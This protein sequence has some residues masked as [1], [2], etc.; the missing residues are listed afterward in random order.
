MTNSNNER[1]YG[2]YEGDSSLPA[3]S[4][5]IVLP[6]NPTFGDTNVLGLDLILG[7]NAPIPTL[8]LDQTSGSATLNPLVC[9]QLRQFIMET[10]NSTLLSSQAREQDPLPNKKGEE[11]Q[12]LKAWMNRFLL[13]SSMIDPTLLIL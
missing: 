8:A 9:E 7:A 1:D 11:H 3:A 12:E 10:I 6:T 2:S 13:G 4:G 5:P